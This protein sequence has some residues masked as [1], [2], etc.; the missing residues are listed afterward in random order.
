LVQNFKPSLWNIFR[1]T[2][3]QK[4]VSI[5]KVSS[6][7]HSSVC[8]GFW[9]WL[10]F[11]WNMVFSLQ[12]WSR[13]WQTELCQWFICW[14]FFHV[15]Y[16]VTQLSLKCYEFWSSQNLFVSISCILLHSK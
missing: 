14:V 5:G 8:G 9:F 15:T 6:S 1:W 10:S 2:A 11:A 3:L 13:W 12:N 7:R 16:T 4:C